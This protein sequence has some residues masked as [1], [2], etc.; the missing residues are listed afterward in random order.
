M[1]DI[2]QRLGDSLAALVLKGNR[3]IANTPKQPKTLKLTDP[4]S[5]RALAYPLRLELMA[6]PTV[7]WV[8][9]GLYR[10]GRPHGR[11]RRELFVSFQAVG[12]VGPGRG[13]PARTG[14]AT[15]VACYSG[16]E[17]V[18]DLVDS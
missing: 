8:L 13:G 16:R 6:P 18:V 15:P 7:S 3:A 12:P 10:S 1:H 4:R 14:T 17:Y 11:E 2:V 9:D 5:L